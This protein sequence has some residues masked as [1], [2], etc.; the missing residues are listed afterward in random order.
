M[1]ELLSG[2]I[3]ALIGAATTWV[4]LRFKYRDLFARTVSSNRMDWINSFRNELSVVVAALRTG[5]KPFEAEEARSKLLT[6]INLD[7]SRPGNEY[8]AVF[9]EWLNKADF[10]NKNTCYKECVAK[11]LIEIS[12][13]ILQY[14]WQRVKEEA[15]GKK[16]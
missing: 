1:E 12:R 4:T 8:N 14:E 5:G 9:L 7:T 11:K 15:R 2:I 16:K 13:N 10:K 6:R 3:G